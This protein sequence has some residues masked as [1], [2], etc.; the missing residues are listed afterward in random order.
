MNSGFLLFYGHKTWAKWTT[1]LSLFGFP[2]AHQAL[3]SV[4]ALSLSV[5][6]LLN[7]AKIKTK[8]TKQKTKIKGKRH[9]WIIKG[10]KNRT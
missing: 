5:K 8:K 6:D 9:V 3:S 10:M 2:M 4:F 1:V 7:S